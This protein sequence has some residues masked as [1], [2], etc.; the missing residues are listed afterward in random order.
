MIR[1]TTTE[2]K[3]K[4][5]AG[6]LTEQQEREALG[7]LV[8]PDARALFLFLI[9]TGLRISEALVVEVADVERGYTRLIGKGGKER[10]VHYRPEL[11]RELRGY[12][13]GRTVRNGQDARRLFPFNRQ[14][15]Y[16]ILSVADIYP[17]LLRHTYLTRLLRRT[18]DIRL[19]Q[20]VAGHSDI[21]TTSKYTHFTTEEI[22]EA[23]TAPRTVREKLRRVLFSFF[24]L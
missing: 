19:V 12:L 22:R 4:R 8:R 16:R 10:V 5:G 21:R 24:G 6:Y 20:E 13:K 18:K 1:N 17:H 11:V 2:P 14:T 9:E 3:K 23:M 7:R 15:A